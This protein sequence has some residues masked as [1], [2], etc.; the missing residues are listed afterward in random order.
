MSQIIAISVFLLTLVFIITEK[1][2]RSIAASL[3]GILLIL[4]EVIAF[5]ESIKF[6]DFN[7]LGLLIGM[8][9]IVSIVSRT[10]LFEYIAIQSVKLVKG[11]PVKL[12]FILSATTALFSAFLDDVTTIILIIPI[13]LFIA[14]IIKVSPFP[15]VIPEILFSNIGGAATI[16]GDPPNIIIASTPKLIL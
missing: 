1:V 3:G 13:T 8:M 10:G 4:T 16:I 12:L 11:R 7:V 15:Y 14:Q 9:L 2:N 5:E 6:I